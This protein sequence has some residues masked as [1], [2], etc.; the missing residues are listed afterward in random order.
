MHDVQG[1]TVAKPDFCNEDIN[2]NQLKFIYGG[3][4]N[5]PKKD[6]WQTRYSYEQEF[7]DI[8][9]LPAQKYFPWI[10]TKHWWPCLTGERVRPCNIFKI[11]GFENV[12]GRF[13]N[14]FVLIGPARIWKEIRYEKLK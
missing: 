6:T 5:D 7:G 8:R 1:S 3:T 9:G 2:E 4:F 13:S 10:F 14:E 11:W 12:N